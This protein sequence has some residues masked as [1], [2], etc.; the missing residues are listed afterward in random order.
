MNDLP[1]RDEHDAFQAIINGL[2]IATSGAQAMSRFRP[3][4]R[5]AWL[6]LAQTYAV[7]A[8]SANKLAEE[9]AS[10]VLKS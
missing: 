8:E 10:R 4:T 1:I 2:K 9:A 7:C 6:M 3:D 5:D